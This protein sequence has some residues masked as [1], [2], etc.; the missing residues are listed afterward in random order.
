MDLFKFFQQTL[1]LQSYG[2]ALGFLNFKQSYCNMLW[3]LTFIQIVNHQCKSVYP[4]FGH[5]KIKIAKIMFI[6][7][8]LGITCKSMV[9]WT[10]SSNTCFTRFDREGKLTQGHW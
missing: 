1:E 2:G 4:T 5:P 3:D 7:A 10:I 6:V 8:N 9:F